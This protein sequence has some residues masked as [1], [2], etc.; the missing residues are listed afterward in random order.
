MAYLAPGF[1]IA[2]VGT[3]SCVLDNGAGKTGTGTLVS[4]KYCHRDITAITALGSGNYDDFATAV[5]VAFDAVWTTGPGTVAI[6]LATSIYTLTCNT[7]AS[8]NYDFTS[9]AGQLLAQALGFHASGGS[10]GSGTIGGTGYACTLSGA[11]TYTSNV[12]PYYYLTI[13]KDGLIHTDGWPPYQARGQTKGI[14]TTLAKGYGISPAT[15]IR[16]ADFRLGFQTQATTFAQNATTEIPWTY[17]A[18]VTHAGVWEPVVFAS[19]SLNFVY[20]DRAGDFGQDE[21]ESVWSSY[22]AQWHIDV[23]AQF[24]GYL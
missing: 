24:L 1:D 4:A 8:P 10:V 5:D 11:T 7:S 16:F 2:R 20:K 13:A 18:L 6:D 22:H 15:K 3:M 23:A 17:E 12:V 9:T 21:R 14:I 19:T